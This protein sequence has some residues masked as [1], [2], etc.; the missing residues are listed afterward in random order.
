MIIRLASALLMLSATSIQAQ[1]LPWLTG[2][3]TIEEISE[4]ESSVESLIQAT[5][6]VDFVQQMDTDG[7]I[8]SGDLGA[9]DFL[10][11]LSEPTADTLFDTSYEPLIAPARR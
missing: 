3:N 5:N 1:P 8:V 9:G 11:A 7:S 2:L 6:S 10:K 4:P